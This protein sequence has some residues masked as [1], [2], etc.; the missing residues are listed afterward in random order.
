MARETTASDTDD[1]SVMTPASLV[2][3]VPRRRQLLSRLTGSGR[4]SIPELEPLLRTL[5]QFHPKANRQVVER[6]YVVET[7]PKELIES[8]L[9]GMLQSLDP[10]SNYL[11]AEDFQRLNERSTGA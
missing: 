7:D 9:D 2:Q 10:H 6:A 8:A 1:Q 5:R 3:D 11:N 4:S